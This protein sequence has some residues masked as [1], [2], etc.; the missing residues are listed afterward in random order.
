LSD[1]LMTARFTASSLPCDRAAGADVAKKERELRRIIVEKCG[2]PQE[3]PALPPNPQ[4]AQ[5][6]R[7]QA[8][9][10][11]GGATFALIRTADLP[12]RAPQACK[13]AVPLSQ[14]KRH[15]A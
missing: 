8:G 15:A 10:R 1:E 3:T 7:Q 5:R 13:S 12:G 2:I 11:H 4:P 14:L 9:P 6:S